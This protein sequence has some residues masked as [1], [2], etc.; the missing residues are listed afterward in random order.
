[1]PRFVHGFLPRAVE[2]QQLGAVDQALTAVWHEVRLRGAPL[3][4]GLGPLLRA[5]QIEDLVTVLD[6]GAVDNTDSHGRHFARGNRDHHLVEQCDPISD[7]P[8]LEHDLTDTEAAEDYE[9]WVLK[10]LTDRSSF[11]ERGVGGVDLSRSH[12]T[13]GD[14]DQ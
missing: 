14:G 4:Q 11:G 2:L 10:A 8:P 5:P 12:A 9:L 3:P 1:L 6:H 13:Q 7:A